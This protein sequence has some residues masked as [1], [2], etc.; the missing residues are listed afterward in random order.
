MN[1]PAPEAPEGDGAQAATAEGRADEGRG[2][3][4]ANQN[5]YDGLNLQDEDVGFIQNR[6]Y[7]NVSSILN[8]VRD[9]E[10]MKGVPAN[11]LL[12][13]PADMS[14][15]DA[16]NEVYEALGRPK[17]PDEYGE[18][19]FP[20]SYK[21][22]I[23]D[24]ADALKGALDPE[25][26]KWADG[27][28]HKLG[29]SKAQ[30]NALISET[31]VY[32]SGLIGQMQ[33]SY[34][35]EQQI[36]TEALKKEWGNAYQE[37]SELGRRAVRGFLPEGVDKEKMLNAIEQAIG[38]ATML[39]L[40]ANVGEATSKEHAIHTGAEGDRPFGKT[41]EQIKADIKEL[42]DQLM[43]DKDRLDNYNKQKGSDYEKM[44]RLNKMLAQA[45]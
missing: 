14:Q 31:L 12:K 40:F 4:A 30:R 25:R 33:E 45:G 23:G 8:N 2:N 29:L 19:Q 6:G 42:S 28:A 36:Q 18:F 7:D 13:L 9:F 24:K 11:Q 35:A 22:S 32:E 16:L 39:K 3:E 17:T 37:R 38:S 34:E 44:Q 10:K 5:W 20:E 26:A 21:E 41:S 1:Q 43:G 27:V 15:P